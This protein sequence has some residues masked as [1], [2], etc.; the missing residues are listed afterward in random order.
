[1][2]EDELVEI[3]DDEE[4]T[5]DPKALAEA[6]IDLEK[7]CVASNIELVEREFVDGE[8]YVAVGIPNGREKR[9]VSL[10]SLEDFHR[11][12]AF[13]FE[14]VTFLGD[15]QAICSYEDGRIEAMIRGIG[16]MGTRTYL[17]TA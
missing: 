11:L 17:K 5:V 7:R 1:M 13:P 9:W 10:Y 14:R 8:K 6:R 2:D 16:P 12:L 3:V 15:Y 4:E